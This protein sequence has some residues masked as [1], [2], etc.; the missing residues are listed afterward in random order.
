MP[1]EAKETVAPEL[2]TEVGRLPPRAGSRLQTMYTS[3]C[4]ISDS[5]RLQQIKYKKRKGLESS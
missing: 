3:T 4:Q 5:I 1:L 2:R